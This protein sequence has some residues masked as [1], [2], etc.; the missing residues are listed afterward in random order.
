MRN[1][2]IAMVLC[3]FGMVAGVQAEPSVT[4]EIT[5]DLAAGRADYYFW[6]E[7]ESPEITRICGMNVHI[8]IS[9]K[10]ART[11]VISRQ[12]KFI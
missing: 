8:P 6:N 4:A 3:L 12:Y 9:S 11:L 7:E 2:L 1:R 5:Y 10:L